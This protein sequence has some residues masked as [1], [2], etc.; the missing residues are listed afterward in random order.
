MVGC[1]P[2]NNRLEMYV[3][4]SGLLD[5]F[6]WGLAV[7][8][9]PNGTKQKN[10]AK[11]PMNIGIAALLFVIFQVVLAAQTMNPKTCFGFV[12]EVLYLLSIGQRKRSLIRQIARALLFPR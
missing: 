6:F 4:L 12:K 5:E 3:F 9:E 11:R 1:L 10:I 8:S 7:P 2:R